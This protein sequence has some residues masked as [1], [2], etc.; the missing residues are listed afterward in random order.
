MDN[1]TR[2]RRISK[3]IS[4][5]NTKQFVRGIDR[6]LTACRNLD[7]SIMPETAESMPRKE[8]YRTRVLKTYEIEFEKFQKQASVI[9]STTAGLMKCHSSFRFVMNGQKTGNAKIDEK[10]ILYLKK[11]RDQQTELLFSIV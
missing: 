5:M 1:K 11:M 6:F 3:I 2:I 7:N 9:T 4:R 8:Q 10:T